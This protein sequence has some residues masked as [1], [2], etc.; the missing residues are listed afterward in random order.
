MMDEA[1][2]KLKEWG[3]LTE[4]GKLD[5]KKLLILPTVGSESGGLEAVITVD[6]RREVMAPEILTAP[7]SSIVRLVMRFENK[8]R[9]C[10]GT[11]FIVGRNK[12]V[13][14]GHCFYNRASESFVQEMVVIPVDNTVS[15]STIMMTGARYSWEYMRD[16]STKNDWCIFRVDKNIGDQFGVL[17]LRNHESFTTPIPQGEIAGYPGEAYGRRT[18]NMWTAGGTITPVMADKV[19]EYTF[20]T[21][22]GQSGAPVIVSVG[23]EFYAVGIH[24]RV[25]GDKN[26]A[27]LIDDELYTELT[28][29]IR[30]R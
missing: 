21:S 29:Y 1:R 11:G 30:T 4:D 2:E 8:P 13:T 27:R 22:G 24:S 9:P 23:G 15:N 3:L 5:E 14:A 7:Y 6:N 12:I 25:M 26:Y 18:R 10:R 16:P 28:D 17:Q 20:A 19:Y